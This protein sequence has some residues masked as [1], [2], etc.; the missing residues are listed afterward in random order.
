MLTS[1]K[2]YFFSLIQKQL[3]QNEIYDITDNY[4]SPRI[5]V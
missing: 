3:V 4:S 5:V 2:M 1:M